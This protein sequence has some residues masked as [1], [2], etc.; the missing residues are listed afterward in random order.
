MGE[1]ETSMSV[2]RFKILK[3]FKSNSDVSAEIQNI[4][5]FKRNSDVSAEIQNIKK[6]QKKQ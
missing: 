4:K 6:I 2:L 5:I 3:R 1:R